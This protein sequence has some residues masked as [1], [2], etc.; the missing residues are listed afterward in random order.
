MALIHCPDCGTEVSSLA[1]AC[2]KCG[3]PMVVAPPPVAA[4]VAPA[5]Q[6]AGCV[7]NGFRITAACWLLL[8]LYTC[9]VAMNK[10][11]ADNGAVG[12]T[13]LLTALVFLFPGLAILA[14]GEFLA[15]RKP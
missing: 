3:R 6:G 8:G 1:T 5:K 4:P 7:A 15:R 13:V 2:P 14:V 11:K 12:G 10:E 9:S